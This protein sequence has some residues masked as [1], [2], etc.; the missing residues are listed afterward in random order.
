MLMN[1]EVFLVPVFIFKM[2]KWNEH[3][4]PLSWLS[5][6]SSLLSDSYVVVTT[7]P[8]PTTSRIS[9]FRSVLLHSMLF[10]ANQSLTQ[11]DTILNL[12]RLTLTKPIPP[13]NGHMENQVRIFPE[14]HTNSRSECRVNRPDENTVCHKVYYD[15][16]FVALNV[17]A[18]E[19][20]QNCAI[21]II[22][23][24]SCFI[25]PTWTSITS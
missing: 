5:C 19:M 16:F 9:L 22:Q 25:T 2:R 17:E 18:R 1:F 3:W 7:Q 12:T 20:F 6:P 11:R 15:Y 23:I 10:S 24:K 8:N 13:R 4:V 14:E 21:T